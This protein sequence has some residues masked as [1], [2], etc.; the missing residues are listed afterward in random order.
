MSPDNSQDFNNSE[1][2]MLKMMAEMKS[3]LAGYRQEVQALRQQLNSTPNQIVKA[4]SETPATSR[5][6]MLK[7]VVAGAAGVGALSFL[8]STQNL[9]FA[10]A[11]S[12]TA[13]VATPGPLGYALKA[14][15]GGAANLL[16]VQAATGTGAPSANAHVIGE[17]YVD[18]AG[19]LF[20]C[21]AAGTP[22]TWRQLAGPTKSGS[23]QA[24]SPDRFV[25]TRP[26]PNNVGGQ[27]TLTTASNTR[28]Y[29]FVG[30][31]AITG[32]NG[33]TIPDNAT[34]LFGNL[35]F[36]APTTGG[37]GAIYPSDFAGQVS[38]NI[39]FTPGAVIANSFTVKIATTGP[40]IGSV[41]ILGSWL[42]AGNTGDVIVD[43][44]GY[45]A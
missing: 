24:I 9:A 3:E 20:Y 28:T 29:K 16:L 18:S 45:Y 5:R 1:T 32:R 8:T 17:L 25:D 35:T 15:T 41:T 33:T 39:N 4:A 6:R 30:A 34:A 26:S 14:D 23:F 43:I 21:V 10:D 22:G 19:S 37:F 11:T 2:E 44:F 38:S 42:G 7:R 31:G 12:D 27:S 13:V 40:N 36:V